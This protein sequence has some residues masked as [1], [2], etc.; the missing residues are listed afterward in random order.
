[1]ALGVALADATDVDGALRRYEQERKKR[2]RALIRLGPRIARV[3]TT[4]NM[5]IQLAR[6]AVIRMVPAR[7]L[8]LL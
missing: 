5:A 6:A 7:A 4:R 3:T 2:T 1:V 8:N